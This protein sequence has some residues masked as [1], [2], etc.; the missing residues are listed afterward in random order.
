LRQ[1]GLAV[2]QFHDING[3]I[4]P[5]LGNVGPSAWGS[6]WYHL[7]PHIEQNSLY[8]SSQVDGFYSAMN[9][10]AY[11]RPIKLW[12]C[13]SDPSFPGDG[14]VRDELG[15][16]WGAIT[17]GGNASLA[18]EVDPFGNILS[19][20]GGARIPASIP[21]GTS[22]TILHVEKYA[23]CTN[24]ANPIGG[25]AWAYCRTDPNAPYLWH[26]IAPAVDD[27]LMFLTQPTPFLG[28]CDP[29]L[30]STGHTR[31]MMV[32]LVD[33]SVCFVASSIS[34]TTWWYAL[35]PAGGEILPNDW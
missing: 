27:T 33:G 3:R 6:Y 23:I 15:T 14:T 24:S 35:T 9:N 5:A 16:R 7:L 8:Q 34:P 11:T 2:Q 25:T 20:Q 13:P 30:A 4:P 29:T 10:Q 18:C 31:G 1:T 26:G 28:N 12:I 21:D 19:M 32:G 22:N 17:Y